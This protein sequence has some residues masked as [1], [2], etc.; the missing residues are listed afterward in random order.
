MVN[1]RSMRL[2][3]YR[4]VIAGLV[5]A[6]TPLSGCGVDRPVIRLCE[7]SK[8]SSLNASAQSVFGFSGAQLMEQA[9]G[10][11]DVSATRQAQAAF[12]VRLSVAS[13]ADRA[14]QIDAGPNASLACPSTLRVQAHFELAGK[15]GELEG[16]WDGVIVGSRSS[17][18]AGITVRGQATVARGD[19]TLLPPDSHAT[20]YSFDTTLG[21]TPISGSL[22]ELVLAGSPGQEH[23]T[24]SPMFL[25]TWGNAP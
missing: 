11:Y 19:F 20:S 15:A 3:P 6:A 4:L 22:E 12:P 18:A 13:T 8:T 17:G 7:P 10:D 16:A 23:S 14:D 2:L 21:S 24:V 9:V 1:L 5:C 25:A